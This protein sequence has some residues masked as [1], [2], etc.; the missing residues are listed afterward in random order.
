MVA[1]HYLEAKKISSVPSKVLKNKCKHFCILY[2]S[3]S[4]KSD[5]LRSLGQRV[6]EKKN[7]QRKD[8]HEVITY[9]NLITVDNESSDGGN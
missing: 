7:G 1:L 6:Y 4:T 9:D 5:L 3:T 2:K 8:E